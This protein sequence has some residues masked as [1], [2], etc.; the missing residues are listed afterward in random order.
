MDAALCALL[1]IHSY[2]GFQSSIIDYFP[3]KRVPVI[4]NL[5]M[6]TLRVT[7]ILVGV[8]LYEFETNDVG[9]TEAVK[10]VWNA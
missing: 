1:L 3:N 7:T 4:R 6:W 5:L 10:R 2:V 8:S 9:I